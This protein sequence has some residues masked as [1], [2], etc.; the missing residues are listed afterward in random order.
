V[1]DNNLLKNLNDQQLAAIL[2]NEGPSIIVAGAGVGKTRVL[3][4]KIAY[5]IA[6][7]KIPSEKI[8]AVT[9]TNKAAKEM[10]NRVQEILNDNETKVRIAT[11]HS[12]C[13]QILRQEIAVLNINKNFNIIDAADQRQILKDIYNRDFDTKIEASELRL[14]SS[15]ISE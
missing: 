5:L 10:K 9:F 13:A 6:A 11:Y 14:L 8:L 3:T 12:L 1:S 4:H 2:Y 7:L 15:Y